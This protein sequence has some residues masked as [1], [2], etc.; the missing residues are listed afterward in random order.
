[1]VRL[2]PHQL[3]NIDYSD[4]PA[5][6]SLPCERIL[7]LEGWLGAR[8]VRARRVWLLVVWIHSC[9]L[10]RSKRIFMAGR[11][12]RPQT[13][14]S[15][16]TLQERNPCIRE[17]FGRPPPTALVGSFLP[18]LRR[19]LEARASTRRPQFATGFTTKGKKETT[20]LGTDR[21]MNKGIATIRAAD[22][23][24]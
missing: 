19:G 20:L 6:H 3:E 13:W 18:L 5:A 17:V 10:D 4:V 1:M 2:L 23:P 24:L 9:L 7:T 22:Y 8:F 15:E 21:P 12:D 16:S 11:L 14:A